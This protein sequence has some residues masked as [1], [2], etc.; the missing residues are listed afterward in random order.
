MTTENPPS[1]ESSQ[2]EHQLHCME[3]WKGNR[4]IEQNV[5]S[6]GIQ[7]WVFS[8]P[9]Q[10]DQQGGDIHYLSLC[11]GGIVTRIVLAD[12]AGHGD[13]VAQTSKVLLNLLRKFMNTK[14]Q[15][16]LVAELNRHFTETD[17][18]DGFATAIV[19]TYLSHKSIL[20]LTN[21]GHPRPLIYKQ[22]RGCWEFLDLPTTDKGL[23]D[24]YPFGLDESTRYEHFVLKI[25]PDDWLLLYTDAYTE[26][27]D[28]E[29][30]ILGES[31][32]L[33]LVKQLPL[34]LPVSQFGRELNR[35]LGSSCEQ[36]LN[37][38]D[39][40]LI[41]IRFT[42]HRRSPSVVEKLVGY[43]RVLQGALSFTKR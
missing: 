28:L 9:F 16:R 34:S 25:E 15:D 7:A 42:N 22:S 27:C 10:G 21:A 38:D 36:W 31:G 23:G 35:L 20:L 26:S 13:R 5:N 29:D 1:D 2:R 4:F 18:K 33:D 6:A 3:I 32:L 37:D 39:T 14:K 40:T 19:A 24:N 41:A 11:V 17:E 12:V 43:W 8:H 30:N